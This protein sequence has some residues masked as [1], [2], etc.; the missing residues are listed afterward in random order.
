VNLLVLLVGDAPPSRVRAAVEALPDPP[1]RVHVVA[2]ALSRPLDWLATAEG[3][4]QR[5]ADVRALEIEW[6]LADEFAVEGRYGEADPVQAVED[7][8]RDFEADEILVAGD[9]VDRDLVPAL[10]QFR[11]PVTRLPRRLPPRRS[12][13]Y[14]GLRALAAGHNEATPFVLFVGVN[15]ALLLLGVLISGFVLLVLWIAGYL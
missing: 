10:E 11:L 1:T 3:S 8:L 9:K 14:R 2:P 5:E 15:V 6:S 12:V 7:A 4:A 13:V